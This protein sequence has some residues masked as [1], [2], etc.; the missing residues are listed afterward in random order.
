MNHKVVRIVL[1]ILLAFIAL[2]SIPSG[3]AMITGALR[4]PPEFLQG[5]LFRDYTIPGLVLAIIVGGSS[6]LAAVAMF[7]RREWSVILSMVAGLMMAGYEVVE[8][9]I[10]QQFSWL[11]V[12]YFAIGAVIFGLAG[13]LWMTEYRSYHFHT[14]HASHA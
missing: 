7:I 13:Y 6:L 4:I 8:L 9:A 12:L 5:T 1:V 14:R 10:I 3:V 2:T 11:Q